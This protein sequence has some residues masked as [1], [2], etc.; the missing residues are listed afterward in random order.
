LVKT[1][2]AID[3]SAAAWTPINLGSL[4]ASTIILQARTAVDVLFSD[5]ADPVENYLT[6]KSGS[7]LAIDVDG[8]SGIICYAKAASGTPK[9]EV[10]VVA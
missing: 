5:A 7:S 4:R 8:Q 1:F 10:L 6:I 9:L 2:S 3:L